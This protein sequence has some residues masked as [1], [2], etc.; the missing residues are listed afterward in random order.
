MPETA[1]NLPGPASAPPKPRTLPWVVRYLAREARARPPSFMEVEYTHPLQIRDACRALA[2]ELPDIPVREIHLTE[3]FT[4]GDDAPVLWLVARLKEQPAGAVVFVSGFE[5][6]LPPPGMDRNRVLSLFNW[7]RETIVERPLHQVWWVT[8][9]VAA[10]LSRAISDLDSWFLHRLSLSDDEAHARAAIQASG[11]QEDEEKRRELL[12]RAEELYERADRLDDA[13][14]Y[15]EATPLLR[16]ALRLREVILGEENEETL[17]AVNLLAL[18]LRKLGDLN[19]TETLYRRT[20]DA[21]ERTLG[22]EHTNT[23]TSLNNLAAVL[24]A[25][26]DLAGAEPLYRRALKARERTLGP[27]HPDTLSSLNSLAVL[28]NSKGEF[29]AA[30][31]LFRRALQVRERTLGPEHPNTLTSLNNLAVLLK[32][33]GDRAGAELLYRRALEAR[34]RTLGPEHPN[35]LTSLNNLALLIKAKGDL[36]TAEPLFRRALDASERTLGPKHPDTQ[37][38]RRNL[39]RLQRQQVTTAKSNRPP[40]RRG[41][42]KR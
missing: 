11:W 42:A 32:A 4:A 10:S 8:P 19:V 30:E 12:Q 21:S 36:A 9:G 34:E 18:V 14:R 27:E 1:A 7:Y 2:A 20:L 26:G 35:T 38:Y 28:L 37:L 16:E 24:R 6:V 31:P 33:K 3:P 23:L 39:E 40:R 29:A 15:F 5:G 13:G 17:Q 41:K 25:K 22:S